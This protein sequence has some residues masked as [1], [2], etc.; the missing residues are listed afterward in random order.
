MAMLHARGYERIAAV[1]KYSRALAV[2]P[3]ERW[4]IDIVITLLADL[5]KEDNPRFDLDR[6]HRAIGLITSEES[7]SNATYITDYS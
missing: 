4:G 3:G 6:F 2:T 5:F 7:E 1:L